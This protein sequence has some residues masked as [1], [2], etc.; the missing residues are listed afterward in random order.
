MGLLV[1]IKKAWFQDVVNL[2]LG[3]ALY[4]VMMYFIYSFIFPARPALYRAGL[5]LC[6]CCCIEFFSCTA[7]PGSLL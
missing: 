1:R 7:P 3:D 6:T 4:A 5:A 2:Y